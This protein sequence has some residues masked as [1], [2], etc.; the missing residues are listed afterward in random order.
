MKRKLTEK[1]LDRMTVPAG[2]AQLIVWDEELPA[3]GAV[4][5]KNTTTFIANY[6]AN[7]VKRRQ[8]IGRRGATREDGHPWTVTL[9]RLRG[10]EILG[11]V[12]GGVDPRSELRNRTSGP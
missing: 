5:G 2:K 1:M 4:V 9:A 3:F 10:R 11:K 8:V 12:A 6:W 7:G